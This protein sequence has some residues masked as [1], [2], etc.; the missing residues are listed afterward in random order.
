MRCGENISISTMF[1][2][3]MILT[4]NIMKNINLLMEKRYIIILSTKQ[5]AES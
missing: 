4:N 2:I 5:N 1:K 3:S